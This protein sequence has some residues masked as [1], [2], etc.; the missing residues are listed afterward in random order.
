MF[1]KTNAYYQDKTYTNNIH[2]LH[3]ILAYYN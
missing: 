2:Y 1:L 3:N